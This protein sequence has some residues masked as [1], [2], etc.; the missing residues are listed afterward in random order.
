MEVEVHYCVQKNL[1]LLSVLGKMNTIH[2]TGDG[3]GFFLRSKLPFR[4]SRKVHLLRYHCGIISN[5]TS[6]ATQFTVHKN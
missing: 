6:K 1:Q 2:I 5:Y 3:T 4:W